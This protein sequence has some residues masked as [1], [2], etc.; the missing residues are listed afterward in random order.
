MFR[1]LPGIAVR[2]VTGLGDES[3]GSQYSGNVG[4]VAVSRVGF[5]VR[6]GDTI[7]STSQTQAFAAA[8][9]AVALEALH[10]ILP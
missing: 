1:R 10:T 3:F 6:V 7:Y 5:V 4:G 8:D 9:P 2:P